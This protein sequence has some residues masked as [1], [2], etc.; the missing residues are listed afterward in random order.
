MF[1]KSMVLPRLPTGQ[2]ILLVEAITSPAHYLLVIR[3]PKLSAAIFL[4]LHLLPP[5]LRSMELPSVRHRALTQFWWQLPER[6]RLGKL[7]LMQM[8]I[9]LPP[10]HIA[11]SICPTPSSM[12]T[13]TLRRRSLFPNWR[14]VLLDKFCKPL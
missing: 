7:S 4:E 13:S 10:S 11:N 3:Q 5:L 1:F 14:Q 9:I 6:H 8:L 2:S 12:P